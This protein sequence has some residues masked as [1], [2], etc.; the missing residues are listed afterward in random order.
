[1]TAPACLH[2]RV[3]VLFTSVGNEAI[4]GFVQDLRLRAP[5]WRLIGTDVKQASAGL[6]LCDVAEV[7]PFR[8]D[9]AYLPTLQRICAQQGVD[10]LYPL[11]TADQDYFSDPAIQNALPGVKVVVS[12]AGAIAVSNRK[13]NLFQHL[14]SD[15][16]LL[17]LHA[18]VE[19]LDEAIA[20][21]TRTIASHGAAL[22]KSDAGTGGQGMLCIGHPPKDSAPAAGRVWIP[23]A[24]FELACL[25]PDAPWVPLVLPGLFGAPAATWPRLV[26]AYLPGEEFSVDVLADSGEML[27]CVVRKRLQAVQGMATVAVVVAAPDVEDAA[28]RVIAAT[29]LSYVANVQFRRDADGVPRL[30]EINPRIPGTIHLTVAAGLNLP[31]AACTQALRQPL[32]LPEP[33]LGVTSLRFAG[34]VFTDQIQHDAP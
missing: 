15:P 4:H 7:V 13:V 29:G 11:S 32:E 31:L 14:H 25:N 28:R 12:S 2:E 5:G 8:N 6:W 24:V 3:T 19:S 34:C 21:L 30:L 33:T 23:T 16:D 10:L 26:M 1:M 22:L 18:V 20:E 17:G 27:A 9:P